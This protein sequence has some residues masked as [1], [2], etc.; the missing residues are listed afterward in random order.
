M[1][2]Q[3]CRS[4]SPLNVAVG[5]DRANQTSEC[6]YLLRVTSSTSR[7]APGSHRQTSW[8]KWWK[9]V[10]SRP[11]RTATRSQ[12]QAA[13][14]RGWLCSSKTRIMP[15]TSSRALFLPS[16]P[17]RDW[18]ALWWWEGTVDISWKMPFSWSSRLLRPMGLV[19]LGERWLFS[20]LHACSLQSI[21]TASVSFR[22]NKCYF[23]HFKWKHLPPLLQH[24][25]RLVH[26]VILSKLSFYYDVEWFH[27]ASGLSCTVWPLIFP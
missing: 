22:K 4:T 18:R 1:W 16:S 3:S 27:R 15:R 13:W 25:L 5:R 9:S 8:A 14:E 2:K 24:F 21:L 10:L 7:L 11:T 20:F 19:A 26:T 6:V 12:E 23:I 17:L